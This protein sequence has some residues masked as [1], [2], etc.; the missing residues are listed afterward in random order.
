MVI[1]TLAHRVDDLAGSRAAS[2][3]KPRHEGRPGHFG[4]VRFT[5]PTT[6][7]ACVYQPLVCFILQGEK[8]IDTGGRKV[9][10]GAGDSVV[11]SHHLP[12]VAR[13]TR[14]SHDAPYLALVASLDLA[15]LR[16]LHDELGEPPVDGPPEACSIAPTVPAVL[17]VWARVVALLDDPR[18]AGVLAPLLLRELH[19][20]LLTTP[21]GTMLRRL[22]HHDS[23]ASKIA[24]AIVEMRRT[25]RERLMVP[26]LARGVG[27][28]T[29]SF[30]RH[31]KAITGTT[32]LQYQK[33][34]RLTEA[35]RLLQSPEH[36]VSTAAFE[37]G[38]ESA[39]QFSREYSRK[40]GVPPSQHRGRAGELTAQ[41]T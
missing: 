5:A 25:Y 38:Y 10:V 27:M 15:E 33:D 26:E 23:H 28:S 9:R 21:Q 31:F 14:A 39:T 20:R 16:S 11:V 35:Q 19:Y 41:L 29:S 32:P 2:G 30:H 37:V 13:V 7:E 12:V 3:S 1:D 34:L 18:G 40:F 6:F 24:R 4:T 36:S 17:D 22:L 8:E